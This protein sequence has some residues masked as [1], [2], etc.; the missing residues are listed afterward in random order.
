MNLYKKCV[1]GL[2]MVGMVGFT[3]C[4]D[5]DDPSIENQFEN[6]RNN[7]TDLLLGFD[8]TTY[9]RVFEPIFG[10]VKSIEQ[11][12]YHATWDAAADKVKEGDPSY[13]TFSQFNEAGFLTLS[14]QFEPISASKKLREYNSIE[15]KLDS[16]NRK[17]EAITEIFVYENNTDETTSTKYI[18]R[19]AHTTYDDANKKATVL[20]YDRADKDADLILSSKTVYQLQEN[21]RIDTN[22]YTT[23]QKSSETDGDDLDRVTYIRKTVDE[24]DSHGNWIV[25]YEI[26]EDHYNETPNLYVYGYTKRTIVYY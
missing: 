4:G 23:Y 15:Y 11:I 12:S 26:Q 5:D 16:K 25:T 21:G 14:K 10:K 9:G 8:V 1:I 7:Y 3:G 24:R 17:I 20:L 19:E 13:K 22:S 6:I 2:V 18:S